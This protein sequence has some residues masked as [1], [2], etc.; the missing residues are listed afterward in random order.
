MSGAKPDSRRHPRLLPQLA[1]F[2]VFLSLWTWKLLEPVPVPPRV[3]GGLSAE[4]KFALAKTLHV[5]GYT[6]LT[7]LAATLPL[8]RPWHVLFVLFLLLHGAASEIAQTYVPNRTGKVSDVVLDW[9]GVGLGAAAVQW[10]R[11]R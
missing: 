7:I 9:L 5:G 10:W 4:I 2:L 11:R 8:R 6:F 1:V 3:V